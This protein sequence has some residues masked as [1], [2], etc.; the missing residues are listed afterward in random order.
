M[1]YKAKTHKKAKKLKSCY[2]LVCYLLLL[3]L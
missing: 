1:F 3:Y 2:F